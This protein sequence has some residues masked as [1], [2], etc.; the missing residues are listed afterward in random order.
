MKKIILKI[1]RNE[2]C[3]AK[4]KRSRGFVILFAVTLA[5]IFLSIA[6]GL[7]SIALNEINFGT[8][9]KDTENAFNAAD[10][11]TECAL[12]YD[13][14]SVPTLNAFGGTAVSPTCNLLSISPGSSS[15]YTFIVSMLNKDHQGCAIVTVQTTGLPVTVPVTMSKI[16]S[17]GYNKGGAIAGSCTKPA[18][19]IEREIDTPTY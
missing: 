17:N 9:A 4:L 1:K 5:A 14:P 10:V 8:S 19:V 16:V 7:S 12:F 6:L 2:A 18:G 3:P 11:G 13:N 15:P